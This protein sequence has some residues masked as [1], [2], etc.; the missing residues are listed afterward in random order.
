MIPQ[1]PLCSA[2][3]RSLPLHVSVLYVAVDIDH[4]VLV[5]QCIHQIIRKCRQNEILL[6]EEDELR[7]IYVG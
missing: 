3:I 1:K 5:E 7:Y 4:N 6:L 2:E